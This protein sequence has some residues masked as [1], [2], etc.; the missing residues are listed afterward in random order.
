MC[1]IKATP[2][3]ISQTGQCEARNFLTKTTKLTLI[4]ILIPNA[5]LLIYF[6]TP[7]FNSFNPFCKI[8]IV[9]LI[10]QN[11]CFTLTFNS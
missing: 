4:Y 7:I 6:K 9:V 5:H 10:P 8:S 3:V 1:S 11:W 2:T